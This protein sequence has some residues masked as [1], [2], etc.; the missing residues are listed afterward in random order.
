MRTSLKSVPARDDDVVFELVGLLD[1]CH[2]RLVPRRNLGERVPPHH[3]VSV[4]LP[5]AAPQ[6]QLPTHGKRDRRHAHLQRSSGPCLLG[7]L[8]QHFGGVDLWVGGAGEGRG[9]GKRDARE[10]A[11]VGD[12]GGEGDGHAEGE[13]EGQAVGVGQVRVRGEERPAR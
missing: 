7:V 2:A 10:F 12:S 5:G 1:G 4:H 9:W 11:G 6:Q 8:R 3:R 13:S